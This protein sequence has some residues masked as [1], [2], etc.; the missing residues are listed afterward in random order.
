MCTLDN[1]KENPLVILLIDFFL[2]LIITIVHFIFY[3]L[4]KETD[5]GNIFDAFE[6]SP[7]FD[8]R[9]DSDWGASSHITFHVWE[10]RQEKKYKKKTI[11]VDRTYIDKINAYYFCYKHISH[12]DLLYRGQIIKK[13]ES[14]N[15]V[16]QKDCGII[17]TLNQHLCIADNE[18]CPLYDVRIG[19]IGNLEEYEKNSNIYYDK[20]NRDQNKKIIG[21]L[22]L[23]DG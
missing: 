5:L 16:Y 1:L 20:K 8:F 10:G 22:I 6:S 19:E 11:I 9:I 18:E 7:L 21:K 15:E 23:N 12:K 3:F 2:F 13:E 17:D 14:C 4:I